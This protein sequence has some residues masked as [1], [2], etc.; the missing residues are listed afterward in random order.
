M[1]HHFVRRETPED[2]RTTSAMFENES[3]AQGLTG[4]LTTAWAQTGL[5]GKC[6]SKHA[7]SPRTWNSSD[8]GSLRNRTAQK[9]S[10]G[11]NDEKMWRETEYSQPYVT[12]FRH[13]AALSVPA[14]LLRKLPIIGTRKRQ[15]ATPVNK[16]NSE[17]V[18][19]TL[20]FFQRI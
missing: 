12:F 2:E 8:I 4:D 19:A 16:I 1:F 5:E 14:V 11:Q 15:T 6:A 9:D 20:I 10:E 18:S 3:L 7:R 17:K 13:S